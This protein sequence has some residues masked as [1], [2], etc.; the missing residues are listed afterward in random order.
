MTV[1]GATVEVGS[2]S[3][4]ALFA[5]H[6]TKP[7][8]IR[9]KSAR[10][11]RFRVGSGMKFAKYVAHP[12]TPPRPLIPSRKTAGEIA[13]AEVQSEVGKAVAEANR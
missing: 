9:P 11:L 10:V 8:G 13:R 2:P 7:H 12:G 4:L 1:H 3:R 6:G 5:D